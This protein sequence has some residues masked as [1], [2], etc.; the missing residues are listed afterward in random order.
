MQLELLISYFRNMLYRVQGST[1]VLDLLT[2]YYFYVST[3]KK[4]IEPLCI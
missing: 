2:V 1:S 4:I 3:E